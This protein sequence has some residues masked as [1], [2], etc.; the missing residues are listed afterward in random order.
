MSCELK[1]S[2]AVRFSLMQVTDEGEKEI[3]KFYILIPPYV[4]GATHTASPFLKAQ[5][6]FKR[7]KERLGGE[8]N[9]EKLLQKSG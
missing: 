9:L 7:M 8:Y 3:D 5:A 1:E 2:F 4:M 6:F